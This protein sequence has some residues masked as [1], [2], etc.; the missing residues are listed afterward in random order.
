M[1]IQRHPVDSYDAKLNFWEEFPDYKVHP[2]FSTIWKINHK[3][4]LE[5]SSLFMW[6]LTLCYDRKSSFFNQ[7]EADKWEVV[8]EELFKES[9]ALM[10]FFLYD[11]KDSKDPFENAEPIIGLPISVSFREIINEFERSI[12]SP[13]GLSLR[14]L[15]RKLAERTSF[16][17][18]TPYTIDS[19]VKI[20][21]DNGKTKT[22]QIKGSADA[23]DKMFANTEK[24][25][26]L[27]QKA[28][29]NLR[30]VAGEGTTKGGG[31]ESLSDGDKTF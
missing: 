15:E 9:T 12:D 3:E 13:L 7:P 29:E 2:L 23:L 8:S 21:D 19:V 10:N 17:M 24:I 18:A 30:S 6:A 16:I 4:K 20:E 11:D 26:S 1:A 27:I 31:K 25:N 22:S 14:D 5:K 28:M